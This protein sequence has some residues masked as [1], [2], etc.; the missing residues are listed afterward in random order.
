MLAEAPGKEVLVT[1]KHRIY[2]DKASNEPAIAV[3]VG[4][5]AKV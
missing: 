1:L 3:D 5:T 4:S 2:T